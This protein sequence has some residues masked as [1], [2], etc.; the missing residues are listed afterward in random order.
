MCRAISCSAVAVFI[1]CAKMHKARHC[2]AAFLQWSRFTELIWRPAL[3]WFDCDYT[4]YWLCCHPRHMKASSSQTATLL[5]SA[6]MTWELIMIYDWQ[7]ALMLFWGSWWQSSRSQITR[8]T[9]PH[10]CCARSVITTTVCWWAP[11]F[12]KQIISP[13]KIR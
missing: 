13:L 11:G 6:L 4:T 5:L 7:A 3:P 10:L 1:C 8:P 2:C 9:P 12:R